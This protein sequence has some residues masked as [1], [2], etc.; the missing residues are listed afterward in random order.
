MNSEMDAARE[1]VTKAVM[2]GRRSL[3]WLLGKMPI[4]AEDE[5]QIALMK[6]HGTPHEFAKGCIECIGE[7]SITEAQTAILKYWQEWDAA[8]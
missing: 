3:H 6:K 5:A 7:I 1:T 8:E 4:E 2:N